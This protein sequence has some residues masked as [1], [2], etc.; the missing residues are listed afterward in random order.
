MNKLLNAGF[1]RLWKNKIFWVGM[2]CLPC[3]MALILFCN[4]YDSVKYFDSK[5][6][7]EGF[8][9]GIFLLIGVFTAVFASLFLGT[10]YSDGTLRNKLIVGQNR[11]EIYLASLII[12]FSAT[13]LVCAASI[14]VTFALSIPLFGL[15][16]DPLIP[17]LLQYGIGI[18][19]MASLSSLFTLMATLITSKPISVV[20]CTLSIF[21]LLFAAVYMMQRLD[22][23]EFWY[24]FY[25]MTPN[26]ETV[27]RNPYPNPMY[28]RGTA[29]TVFSF[30]LD[31]LPTG[32]SLQ[33]SQSPVGNENLHPLR[34]CLCSILFT[35]GTTLGGIFAFQRKDLK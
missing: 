29:R 14:L 25:E 1:A 7:N 24:G 9:C 2:I 23:P 28:L 13:L 21:L 26:G 4:Y 31:F 30:L 34:M 32:Q 12:C 8:L 3:M 27:P 15:P 5:Y 16:Q 22:S 17:L 33:L 19:M 18:L 20:T 11:I 35:S 6:S 10:E